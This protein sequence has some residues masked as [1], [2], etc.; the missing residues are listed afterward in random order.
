[1]V[2][3][4]ALP[5]MSEEQRHTA[6]LL[7]RLLGKRTADRYVDFCRLAAG[8]LPLRVSVPLAGHAMREIDAILRQLLATPADLTVTVSP[9]AQNRL[10]QA[11][12]ALRSLGYIQQAADRA[13]TTLAPKHSHR[14]QIERI[15]ATLGLAPDGDV[16]RSWKSVMAAHAKAHYGR[17]LHQSLEVDAQ[18]RSEWQAPFD[19]A[20]R[21][22]MVALQGKYSAYI[23]RLDELLAMPDRKVAV[24]ALSREIPGALPLLSYFF[25][26]LHSA[27]WLDPLAE[28]RLLAASWV[29]LD[30]I[31]DGLRLQHWPAG[32][33]LVR[34]AASSDPAVRAR[35]VAALRAV[36][37][38]ED[39]DVHWHG[40]EAIVAL[41]A[42]EAEGL[43][44][45]LKGWLGQD[46]RLPHSSAVHT[47]LENLVK[48][49]RHEAALGLF[50]SLYRI[51]PDDGRATTL[52]GQHMFEH[53]LPQ[54]VRACAAGMGSD[55]VGVLCQM[56][57]AALRI[58]RRVS[59]DPPGDYSHHMSRTISDHGPKHGIIDALVGEIVRSARL[60]SSAHPDR[61]EA[62]VAEIS[63]YP[64]R[65]LTRLRLHL[66]SLDPAAAPSLAT[67]SLDDADLIGETWCSME[68]GELASA[69]FDRLHDETQARILGAV[70]KVPSKHE[71]SWQ[72][73]FKKSTGREPNDEER[74]HFRASVLREV[75][76]H[77]RQVLPKDRQQDVERHGDPDAWLNELHEPDMSP[78]VAADLANRSIEDIVSFLTD[79]RPSP[80]AQKVTV[81][82]LSQQLRQAAEQNA[83]TFSEGAAKFSGVPAIYIRRIIEA[84]TTVVRNK[85]AVSWGGIIALT[86]TL[87]SRVGLTGNEG[88]GH[89]AD[90]SWTRKAAIE[91]ISV[92]LQLGKEGISFG[93]ESEVRAQVLSFYESSSPAD[94]ESFEETY[95]RQVY[96]AATSTSRGAALELCIQL[97]F[98]LSKNPETAV[99]KDPGN[100]LTALPEIKSILDAEVARSG[101]DGRIPRA[102]IGRYLGW[103]SY[104]AANF[105]A[106]NATN[107]F[108][109][110][111][112]QLRDAVW[113]SH[114][115]MGT[116]PLSWLATQMSDCYRNEI[117]RLAE[118]VPG[119]DREHLTERF[120]HYLVILYIVDALPED[121]Y[122]QFWNDAPI[123]A[124]QKAMWFLG[125]QLALPE[126]ERRLRAQSY[127]DRRLLA[128]SEPPAQSTVF[129]N[130]IGAIGQF[131]YQRGLDPD[132]LMQ[133][134]IA[135]S[136]AGYGPG[137]TF[138]LVDRIAEFSSPLPHRAVE[139]ISTL[140]KNRHLDMM[141]LG[142]RSQNLRA[143]F[144]AGLSTGDTRAVS[145]VVDAINF[146]TV[147]GDTSCLDL[148]PKAAE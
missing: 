131:Y 110:P 125:T 140:I 36:G 91:L 105:L 143:I 24:Q 118:N 16:A 113:L 8:T 93:L 129:Q 58:E 15:C 100:A 145:N 109:T 23:R 87:V 46:T 10:D 99:G 50:G 138:H 3:E 90:W 88:E 98:W 72:E 134:T 68:Y 102:V 111:D 104:F 86:G 52:F 144:V 107:F 62:I 124:R 120:T 41:P 56:L 11:S 1:M 55:L 76:W 9:E 35:V 48:A 64:S 12:A 65:L 75:Q 96:F 117:Q 49:D 122:A 13:V 147:A 135:A 106:A 61:L 77:W 22:L 31:D 53:F 21:G 116:G 78:A 101:A 85:N 5:D 137:Q 33:Y 70:D 73:R 40:A 43:I 123:E 17:E 26:R 20:V 130:E 142:V 81:T 30:D 139:T 25:E 63:K 27:D 136:N 115:Q 89:D 60:I 6:S 132:W 141:E 126:G 146:L 128:A 39:Q 127:W 74:N 121:V 103:L 94:S 133:Q 37:G 112:A 18:F 29:G 28:H 7:Q 92:G 34:M 32:R 108:E 54:D 82:A 57:D 79:W 114:I 19:T 44:D 71:P 51:I 66:L 59:D 148:L 83:L 97:I 2:E 119:A 95:R 45:I 47:I 80:Q 42:G 14:E 67:S 4:L 38:S 69:W 84:L